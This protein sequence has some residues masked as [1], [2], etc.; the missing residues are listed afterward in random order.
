MAVVSLCSSS[1]LPHFT[2]IHSHPPLFPNL[3]HKSAQQ[4][5][6]KGFASKQLAKQ[7]SRD[8]EIIK[9]NDN[10]GASAISLSPFL[11]SGPLLS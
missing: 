11:L 3:S 10:N 6:K 9:Q 7:T 2:L 1:L 5:Y 8:N 4:K